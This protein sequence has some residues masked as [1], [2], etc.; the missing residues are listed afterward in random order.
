MADVSKK[1]IGQFASNLEKVIIA[2][3]S[4]GAEPAAESASPN[5]AASPAAKPTPAPAPPVLDNEALDLGS[6][7]MG[8]VLK[9]AI[10]AVIGAVVVGVL[11]WWLIKRK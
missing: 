8:P 9:R 5:G 3:Q 10:P 7:A 4:G 6:A 1:L 11:L 2:E